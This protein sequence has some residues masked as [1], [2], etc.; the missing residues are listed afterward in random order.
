MPLLPQVDSKK[1]L[2]KRL[3]AVC[4]SFIMAATKVAVDPLLSFLTKV[5]A[6]RVASQS[7]PAAA[8]P[9]REQVRARLNAVAAML[10][11]LETAML[12]EIRTI[13]FCLVIRDQAKFC[14]IVAEVLA[15]DDHVLGS[16][17]CACQLRKAVWIFEADQTLGWQGEIK[18]DQTRVN[19][20]T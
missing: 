4:E 14:S 11:W 7:N 5:T 18:Q 3:K 9:L 2:E 6:V 10:Y 19:P 20:R 17:S 13:T 8:C 15:K 16:M 1:E 12:F